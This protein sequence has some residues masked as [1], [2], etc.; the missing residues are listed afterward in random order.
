MLPRGYYWYKCPRCGNPKMQMLRQDTAL[1]NFPGYC[2]RCK[3]ES[4]MTIEPKRRVV[5]S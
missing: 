4:I 1:V 5:N 2:K 3:T